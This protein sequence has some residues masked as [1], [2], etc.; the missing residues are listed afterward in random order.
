V[1]RVGSEVERGKGWA[2]VLGYEEPVALRRLNDLVASTQ[3][4]VERVQ[5][6]EGAAG[7]LTS[8]QSTAAAKRFVAAMDK[9]S[10]VVE[11]PSPEDGVLPALLFDPKYRA[12]LDDARV[13]AHNLREVSDRLAGC[14]GRPASIAASSAA[15]RLRSRARARTAGARRASWCRWWRSA[16][17]RRRAAAAA[18]SR[19]ARGRCRS[20]TS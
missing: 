11:Q 7:V 2:H 4:L 19:R 16:R 1:G 18:P 12:M 8:E 6:G 3:T 10:R 13:V 9:L 20:P 5:R 14:R 15:S 17:P